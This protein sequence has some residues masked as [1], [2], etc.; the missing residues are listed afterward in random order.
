[1]TRIAEEFQVDL[2]VLAECGISERR[3]WKA[4][5]S[6]DPRFDL[7]T[8][9][10]PRFRFFTRFPGV[11]LEP[12][13]ADDRIAVRRLK[14]DGCRDIL[15]AAIHYLDRRNHTPGKQ[16]R[17]LAADRETLRESEDRAQHSR[18]VLFGDLNMNPFDLGMLDPTHGLGAMMTRDLTRV[19]SREGRGP[20]RFY[21]PM[22]AAMG[23]SDAPGTFY[24]DADEPNNPYW[25][26]LD[27]VLVRP[28]LLDA[29]RDE[30]LR[31]I[32]R[33]D[34]GETDLIRLA[35]VHWK[36]SYSDHLPILFK[37]DVP[38]TSPTGGESEHG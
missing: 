36:I 5:R 14:L 4:L 9:P 29:F 38:L 21:N 33:I 16:Y 1:M 2:L 18:T 34:D 15:L 26:C 28:A 23:R 11:R 24:W 6:K 25:N 32:R 22:W 13:L 37:L 12:W 17:E 19:H 27:G 3:L 10:H 20:L 30:D 8:N 7:P 31:I 35:D